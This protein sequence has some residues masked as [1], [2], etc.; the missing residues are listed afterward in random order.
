M[1]KELEKVLRVLL[2]WAL[3]PWV[4]GSAILLALMMIAFTFGLLL[5][6]R[7]GPSVS[8]PATAQISVII[9]PTLT[10]VPPSPTAFLTRTPT[11]DV[12]PPP[13]AG[14]VN[15][16]STVQV[17]GTSGDGL[18]LRENPGLKGT[19]LFLAPEGE[20]FLIKDGP[21]EID[22]FVWWYVEGKNQRGWGVSNYLLPS[23]VTPI[24]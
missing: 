2:R 19:V 20:A 14:A 4:L 5:L 13:P 15:I 8:T 9:A 12:P 6:T 17:R 7:P 21:R 18:R 10:P 11:M 16:G 3:S 23:Q 22:G 24:P 1:I